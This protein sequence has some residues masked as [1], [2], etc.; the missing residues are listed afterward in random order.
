[1]PCDWPIYV[2]S[3]KDV[4]KGGTGRVPVPCG[5]CAVCQKNRVSSWVFRMQQE[6]KISTSSYFVTLTYADGMAKVT[7]NG[8][9]TLDKRHLQ[10]FFKRLRKLNHEKIRYYAVGEYGSTTERPHYHLILFNVDDLSY[11]EKAWVSHN[12]H[13]K[14]DTLRGTVDIGNVSGASIRYVTK[15]I[16]KDGI[17]PKYKGD[18]RLKEFSLMSKGLGANY[19]TDAMIKYH[20]ADLERNY[21]THRGGFKSPLPAYYRN[22]IYTDREKAIQRKIISEKSEEQRIEEEEKFNK[23]YKDGD[24]EH[25]RAGKK[26]SRLRSF[27]NSNQNRDKI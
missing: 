17:I 11:I 9:L 15:Y 2:D 7:P 12:K 16:N 6:E 21:V 18:D 1:M 25:Y 14:T 23:L 26:R 24:I 10:L 20:K 13:D 4:A 27:R 19:L 3:H 22:R 8:R 5:R